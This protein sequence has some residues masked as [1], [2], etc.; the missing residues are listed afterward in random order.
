MSIEPNPVKLEPEE[1]KA[2]G[3]DRPP[4]YEVYTYQIPVPVGD[5]S[6]HLL[7]D[8]NANPYTI[9]HAILMDGGKN[10]D[11]L[12][13]HSIIFAAISHIKTVRYE[14]SPYQFDAWVVTHWDEDHFQGAIDLFKTNPTIKSEWFRDNAR[15]YA[16]GHPGTNYHG[17]KEE[18]N[19]GEKREDDVLVR[20]TITPSV[21]Y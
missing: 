11:R 15:L 6:V 7:V 20:K 1:H 8:T 17:E 9:K 12:K 5:C 2:E 18:T 21:L 10:A 13:A 19:P 14:F 16:G 4:F 3:D